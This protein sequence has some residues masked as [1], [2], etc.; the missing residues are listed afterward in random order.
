MVIISHWELALSQKFKGI[1]FLCRKVCQ[2]VPVGTGL[3]QHELA[4]RL[5]VLPPPAAS[6]RPAPSGRKW[7]WAARRPLRGVGPEGHRSVAAL[8]S[9]AAHLVPGHQL[10]P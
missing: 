8:S 2:N 1:A 3:P 5:Q 10:L 6:S 7:R 4:R 9:E